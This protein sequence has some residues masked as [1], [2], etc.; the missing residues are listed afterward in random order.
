MENNVRF[1]FLTESEVVVECW[2]GFGDVFGLSPVFL[3]YGCC[4]DCDLSVF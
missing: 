1:T 3:N 2:G 4:C